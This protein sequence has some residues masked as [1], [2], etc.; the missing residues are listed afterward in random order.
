MVTNNGGTDIDWEGISYGD[1]NS[2]IQRKKIRSKKVFGRSKTS[3]PHGYSNRNRKYHGKSKNKR[4][5]SEE[6]TTCFKCNKMGHYVNQCPIVKKI[7]LMEIGENEKQSLLK[8]IKAEE[9]SSEEEEF[10]SEKE[11]DLLNALLEESN[12]H[13]PK[14]RQTT[15]RQFPVLAAL[16]FSQT[17]RKVS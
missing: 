10:S 3:E 2:T 11:E 9:L 17:P 13:R 4:K 14:M 5:F 7:N 1:I 12:L 8:V 6:N 16:M 15:K